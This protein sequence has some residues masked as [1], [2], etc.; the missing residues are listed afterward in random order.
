MINPNYKQNGNCRVSRKE[1][2]ALYKDFQS[3]TL[4]KVYQ[5]KYAPNQR[6]SDLAAEFRRQACKHSF[7][8]DPVYLTTMRKT[9]ALGRQ[10][11]G[12]INGV[13]GEH[14]ASKALRHLRTPCYVLENV[15]LEYDGETVEIDELVI[16]PNKVFA[17]ETKYY[18]TNVVIDAH[19]IIRGRNGNWHDRYNVIDRS[20]ARE[21]V[22]GGILAPVIGDNNVYKSIESVLCFAN[23]NADFEDRLGMYTVCRCADLPLIIENASS[24]VMFTADQLDAMRDAID[25]HSTEG[26][27][28]VGFDLEDLSSGIDYVLGLIARDDASDEDPITISVPAE[29]AHAITEAVETGNELDWSWL[30]Y[31]APIAAAFAVGVARKPVILRKAIRYVRF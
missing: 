15:C 17:V 22:L 31:V 24:E 6:L 19:G 8:N 12:L 27:Y 29:S 2:I 18:T 14:N 28:P 11:G 26:T 23:D 1:L 3:E 5:D 16:A 25:G 9:D 4:R 21:F 20:R 7:E 10:I 30:A 13:R